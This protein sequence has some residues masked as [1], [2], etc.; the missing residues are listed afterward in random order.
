MCGIGGALSRGRDL[1]PLMPLIIEDQKARGPD[2]SSQINLTTEDLRISLAHNRLAILDLQDRSNQ[3]FVDLATGASIVFNGEIYNYRE[4]RADLLTLGE[5]FRTE[6]D[7]EVLLKAVLRWGPEAFVRLNG[8]F[9]FAA[10]NPKT[11]TLLLARD[12]FGVKPCYYINRAR[13]FAFASTTSA[14]ARFFEP[15]ID[16]DYLARGVL[17]N[18]YENQLGSSA[19][20]E[21]RSLPPGHF[22][23]VSENK[24]QISS[25]YNLRDE[26]DN[27]ADRIQSLSADKLERE[28]EERLYSAV[29]LRL[30]ADVPITLSLSG[31]LDSGLI[32]SLMREQLGQPFE[33]FCYGSPEIRGSE[34]LLARS[35]ANHLGL[36]LSFANIENHELGEVFD[37]TLKAQGAPF[38]HPSVMAQNQVFS[39]I[40]KSGYRVSLGGQGADEVFMGYR[41]FQF[42]HIKD[43]IRS[44][45]WLGLPRAVAGL[46]AMVLADSQTLRQTLLYRKRYLSLSPRS[47]PLKDAHSLE[48][49]DMRMSSYENLRDR[50][51]ADV[52]FA[53]LMTLLRYEDRNSMG[54]SIESRMPFLDYRVIEFGSAISSKQKL[55][56]GYGKWILRKIADK[57]LPRTVVWRRSKKAFSLNAE[58]WLAD[59]L[60]SHIQAGVEPR[61]GLLADVLSD[62]SIELLKDPRSYLNPKNFP[63]MVTAYWLGSQL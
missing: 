39:A 7:T 23:E 55:R 9:A 19:Y 52:G 58:K 3:P 27:L 5:T 48:T 41:K 4:I 59:G 31:G 18:L 17:Y 56:L 50:Q 8:M 44:R 10:W 24:F 6:S 62:S 35:T 1:E 63:L 29:N 28:L 26:V 37:R 40:R 12:R 11:K 57:R 16:F 54:H 51:L 25:Y 30:R 32:A 38:A 46:A 61:L 34:A 20:K 14:L 2:Y 21:I 47:S 45:N 15:E 43:L 33:A 60:G 53:S 42:F 13:E 49:L 22:L 36:S